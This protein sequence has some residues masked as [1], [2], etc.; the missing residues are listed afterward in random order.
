MIFKCNNYFIDIEVSFYS[1]AW[2]TGVDDWCTW[3]KEI[4][5]HVCIKRQDLYLPCVTIWVKTLTETTLRSKISTAFRTAYETSFINQLAFH[6]DYAFS[7]W[8]LLHWNLSIMS[9]IPSLPIITSVSCAHS[10]GLHVL[11]RP[12]LSTPCCVL[13]LNKK[14][15]TIIA[16][17]SQQFYHLIIIIDFLY[18]LWFLHSH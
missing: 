14:R 7:L 9:Y 13:V 1:H 2:W 15:N 10:P 11:Y 3:H 18:S 6:L 8:A 17:N 12:V 4:V 5:K 16:C